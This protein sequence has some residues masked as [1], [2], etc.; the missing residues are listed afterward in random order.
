MSDRS[1][2]VLRGPPLHVPLPGGSLGH[3]LRTRM[4]QYR[5]KIAFIDE[6]TAESISYNDL[7]SIS[8]NLS[9]ALRNLNF[10]KDDRIAICSK[11]NIY[12]TCPVLSAL[13]L[14][15]ITTP[16]CCDYLEGEL[17]NTLQLTQP[18]L[19]FCSRNQIQFFLG[20]RRQMPFIQYLVIMDLRESEDGV[21][22]LKTFIERHASHNEDIERFSAVEVDVEDQVAFVIFSSGTTDLPKGA[23]LTHKNILT[24]VVHI[25]DPNIRFADPKEPYLC[26]MPFYHVFGLITTLGMLFCGML[27]RVF[28]RFDD[29]I[30]LKALEKYRISRLS[31]APPL[32]V[33]LA[34]SQL[35]ERFDLSSLKEISYVVGCISEETEKLIKKRLNVNNIRQ[36]YGLTETTSV[37]VAVPALTEKPGSVGKVLPTMSILVRDPDSGESL[38]P[39]QMGEICFK[40]DLVMKGYYGNPTAT[41]QI[42]IEDGWMRTGDLGYF[43][44]DEYVFMV[45]R[46]TELIKYKGYQVPPAQLESLLLKHPGI[47]ECGVV[48]VPDEESGELPMAFV[49]KQPGVSITESEII[50]YVA[51]NVSNEKQLRG[52]V[53]FLEEIPKNT[54]GRMVRRMLR[55]MV[56]DI[57]GT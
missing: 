12:Y 35:V 23:M 20:L 31:M 28:C 55:L 13:Y 49:V 42:F 38:G 48:G 46:L 24:S 44:E 33:L 1:K 56:R 15:L 26:I 47:R 32:V 50:D 34:K 53:R 43:D 14:G 8:Q 39:N 6:F 7:I 18:R 11:N 2:K 27:G 5:H 54:I 51:A 21:E 36:M 19:I 4:L 17:R 22:T 25:T 41:R 40:G 45:D 57:Y 30:F 37:A 29:I 16:M 3:V 10:R 9:N 52:G